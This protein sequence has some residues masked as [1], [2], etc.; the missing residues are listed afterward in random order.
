MLRNNPNS[1]IKIRWP[2]DCED[3]ANQPE[4]CAHCEKRVGMAALSQYGILVGYSDLGV[5]RHICKPCVQK[6]YKRCACCERLVNSNTLYKNQCESCVDYAP[7]KYIKNYSYKVDLPWGG[8]SKVGR[9][10]GV[11]LELEVTG[12]FGRTIIDIQD[13]I[14]GYAAM[15]K[16]ASITKGCEIVTTPCTIDY[17]KTRWSNICSKLTGVKPDLTCGM[18]VHVS[19]DTAW[20]VSDL[21]VGRI[22]TFLHN[23]KNRKRIAAIAGRDSSYHNDFTKPKKIVEGRGGGTCQFDRDRHTAFNCNNPHTFE[24]RIFQ[25]T[26]NYEVLAKNLDF[27]AALMD[28]TS[29]CN[30]SLSNYSEMETFLGFV[31]ARRKEYPDLHRFLLIHPEFNN[32]KTLSI[33]EKHKQ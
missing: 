4:I 26:V 21:Q 18:H 29:S 11:E 28:Y 24:F 25:A 33:N 19:R 13:L 5:P 31:R 9:F 15:K 23:P 30:T 16:D 6:V 7:K 10:F 12:N 22:I 32:Y 2:S 1:T 3:I 20:G 27:C 14:E 8:E 17:H